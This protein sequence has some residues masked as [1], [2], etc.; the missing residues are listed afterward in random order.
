MKRALVTL[1][2]LPFLWGC[3]TSSYDEEDVGYEP[4]RPAPAL[5]T[6]ATG[7]EPPVLSEEEA[8]QWAEQDITEDNADAELEK[9]ESEILE[10]G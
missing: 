10:D 8:S 6:E 9:L 1:A 4:P 3:E 5:E 7:A 2:V